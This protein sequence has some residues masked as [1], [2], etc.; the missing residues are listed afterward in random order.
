MVR[1]TEGTRKTDDRFS[2]DS[3]V[4]AHPIE[5]NKWREIDW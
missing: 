2:V 1:L 5:I 4:I 3:F